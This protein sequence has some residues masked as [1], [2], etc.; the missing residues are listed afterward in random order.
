MNED[1]TRRSRFAD[2]LIRP[3][4]IHTFGPDPEPARALAVQGGEIIG[5]SPRSDGLDDLVGPRTLVVD[6]PELTLLPAFNDTH[7]HLLEATRNASYVS[8]QQARSIAEL[9]EAIRVRAAVT[10]AG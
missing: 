4:A 6:D 7:N 10:P 8:V 5:L 3:G 9:V 2:I 1:P